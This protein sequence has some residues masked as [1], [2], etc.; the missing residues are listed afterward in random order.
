MVSGA[1]HTMRLVARGGARGAGGASKRAACCDRRRLRFKRA[2]AARQALRRG[3]RRPHW[4]G[5][6]RAGSVQA[7]QAAPLTRGEADAVELEAA[8]L[9]AGAALV[10]RAALHPGKRLQLQRRE[11]LRHAHQRLAVLLLQELVGADW[12][13]EGCGAGLWA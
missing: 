10:E 12:R 2:P 11:Q 13:G 6:L 4:H 9:F 8:C 1:V 3:G 7:C 5:L